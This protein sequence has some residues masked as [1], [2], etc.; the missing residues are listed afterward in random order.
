V[1]G[2]LKGL[3]VVA[4][5]STLAGCIPSSN[6]ERVQEYLDREYSG[7][8]NAN[9]CGADG[10][11]DDQGTIVECVVDKA[12]GGQFT[13]T[14]EFDGDGGEVVRVEGMPE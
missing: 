2:G 4:V 6:E 13:I 11:F 9:G 1:R 3:A 12:G 10:L 8:Y 5:A 7:N 14:V